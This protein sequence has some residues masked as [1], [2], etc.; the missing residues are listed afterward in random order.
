MDVIHRQPSPTP[1]VTS[2]RSSRGSFPSFVAP[3]R[4]AHGTTILVTIVHGEIVSGASIVGTQLGLCPY[5]HVNSSARFRAE[6]SVQRTK[7]TCYPSTMRSKSVKTSNIK[8]TSS[9]STPSMP[10]LI[11]SCRLWRLAKVVLQP[12]WT[13]APDLG[14]GAPMMDLM[15]CPPRINA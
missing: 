5:M 12:S 1:S 7:C 11:S 8:F 10:P 14:Y 15:R 2:F 9:P 6:D 13:W 3:R 4:H